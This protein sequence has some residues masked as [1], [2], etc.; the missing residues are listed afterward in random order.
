M[1]FVLVP[2]GSQVGLD[3]SMQRRRSL[4]PTPFEQLEN[5]ENPLRCP[6]KLYEFYLSKWSV[7]SHCYIELMKDQ[8]ENFLLT[9]CCQSH[10]SLWCCFQ[11][12]N[13]GL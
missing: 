6:V 9:M 2:V 1:V 5:I 10:C 12:L 3:A 11:L 7:T 4:D 13:V 8:C